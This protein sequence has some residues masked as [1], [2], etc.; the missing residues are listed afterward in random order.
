MRLQ[1]GDDENKQ[2]TNFLTKVG[3]TSEDNMEMPAPIHQCSDLLSLLLAVYPDLHV[4]GTATASF[5]RDQTILA[6]HNDDV[7]IINHASLELFP[8][9]Y[10]EYLGAYESIEQEGEQPHLVPSYTTDTLSSLDPSSLPPFRLNLKIGAPIMLL[11]NIAPKDG[12]SNGS[13][14]LVKRCASRVIEAT[15][16]TG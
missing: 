1:M 13:R 5:L 12:L 6:P 15:I 9:D 14:L 16:L 3:T 7:K 2:F 8:G 4:P 11:R 10:V